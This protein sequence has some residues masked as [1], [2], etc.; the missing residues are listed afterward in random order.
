MQGKIDP[1]PQYQRGSVWTRKQKQLLMDSILRGMDIPKL[2]LRSVDG[3]GYDFEVVDGQQ[4]LRTIWEFFDGE[5][6]LSKEVELHVAGTDLKGKK[7]DDLPPDAWIEL[8]RF[9]L[10]VVELDAT[11]EEVEEMFVRLQNGTT[12]RAAEIRNAMP[13]NMKLFVRELAEHGFFGNCRFSNT[14]RDYDHVAAQMTRLELEGEPTDVKNTRLEAM[15]RENQEFD[16]KSDKAKKV[17]RVLDYLLTM[18]PS[19]SPFLEKYNAVALYLVVSHL[20]E[21]F[22]VAGR[23]SEIVK[24]FEAFEAKRLADRDKPEDERDSALVRYQE[25]TSHATDGVD[26]LR[27]RM[28]TLLQDLHSVVPDLAPLD[29]QRAFTDAQRKVIWLRDGKRCQLRVHCNGDECDW[30][31]W[32]ADHKSPW[33][34]GGTTTVDNGQVCCPAC[35]LSKGASAAVLAAS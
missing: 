20:L 9:P 8:G 2:Y 21:N 35:N 34:K 23:E 18:F 19:K 10:T 30:D 17:D 3:H 25:R 6:P 24:W 27:F 16:L 12:L 29:P 33:S 15:Y 32:H 7:Y 5:Y 26:S 31:N 14:R 22:H 11:D 1:R 4:R 13:G 28:D